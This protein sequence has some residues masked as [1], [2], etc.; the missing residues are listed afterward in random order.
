MKRNYYIFSSGKLRR[1]ENTVF[2]IPFANAELPEEEDFDEELLAST[3]YDIAETD[4]KNKKVLPVQDI[5]SFYIFAEMSFNTRFLDFCSKNNIP[6][7]FFGR[8]GNYTGTF[9]PKEYL[10]SGFMMVRQ[11]SHYISNK[12]RLVIARK[13]VEG[14]SFNILRNLKYYN[15]RERDLQAQIDTIESL[16]PEIE[17]QEDI[18]TLMNVEGRIRKVYYTAFNE[19]LNTE[20]KFTK[21]SYNP[22]DNPLNAM[23]SFCNAM[24]YTS[25]LSEIYRTQLNPAISYLHEPGERRYS[26]SLDIA[27]IFKPVIADRMIFKLLNSK[28]IQENHFEERLNGCYLKE[29]GRKVIVEDFDSRLKTTIK[30]RTLGKE[31][32]YRRLIRLECYKLIKHLAGDKDYE[33]FKIWW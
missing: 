21:R 23:I 11:V 14:A 16:I 25:V 4:N 13:F 12:K 26:L 22:P 19:I 27:E 31:I 30:H 17:Q 33:P 24:V 2:F 5:D 7:H 18:Q 15:S 29:N 10:I 20:M 9:H 32:S 8:Y 28:Q 1:K 3:D 6:I